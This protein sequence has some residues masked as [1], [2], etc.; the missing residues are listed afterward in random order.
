MKRLTNPLYV[1]D[2]ITNCWN[3]QHTINNLGYGSIYIKRKQYLAHRFIYEQM[4]GQIPENKVLDHICNNKS[5][6]NPEHLRPISNN[7]N[8]NRSRIEQTKC[9][10]GHLYDKENTGIDKYLNRYCKTCKKEASKRNAKHR[11]NW[12]F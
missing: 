8:L 10:R 4:C 12:N 11:I 1:I 7:H 9:K 2:P 6:V 3:W 5:C